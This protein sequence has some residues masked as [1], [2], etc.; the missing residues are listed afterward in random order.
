MLAAPARPDTLGR[1]RLTGTPMARSPRLV[2]VAT[3]FASFAWS[4]VFVSLPF[5]IQR[6]SA[7]DDAATL[8]WTGWIVGITSLVTVLTA[9]L[10]GRLAERGNPKRCYV[11]VESLQGIGFFGVASARTLGELFFARFVLGFMGAS[12]TFAF[13]L[14]GRAQDAGEVRRQVAFIQAA[15]TVGGVIGPLAGAIAAA[16]F[17]FRASFVLGGLILLGCAGLVYWGVAV[18]REPE[19]GRTG[20]RQ[21]R[22]GDVAIAAVIVLVGSTQLFFLAPVLPQV[23]ADLGVEAA[24]TL[25]IGGV[26]IFASSAAAALG[27][28]AAP[29]VVQLASERRLLATLLVASSVFMAALGAVRSVWAYTLVRFIQV[30]FIAPVFPLVVARIAQHAGGD[31][32]GLVNSARIAAA[33]V[34]PVLATSVLAWTSPPAVY[35]LMAALGP[36]CLPLVAL[37][38]PADRGKRPP[39]TRRAIRPP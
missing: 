22:V 3:F 32:I 29:Q 33:F 31:V 9:P 4:F 24:D 19:G 37:P 38:S 39:G 15:L 2:P 17:G 34:G 23:L 36:A 12:S 5:H 11:L 25:E 7:L 6:L 30:L 1:G 21:L 35:L 26:V 8:R 27:A 20:K 13:M 16:R 10:W 28:F 14:A 18:P